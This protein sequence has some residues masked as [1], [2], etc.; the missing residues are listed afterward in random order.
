MA[1]L[2]DYIAVATIVA[3]AV[4]AAAIDVRTRRVPNALNA[5][6]ASI[7]LVLAVT[8]LSAVSVGAAALGLGV[9]LALMLP[10]FIFGA[11]GAGDVKL[12]AAMGTLVGPM[13]IVRA[14]VFTAI[15]GGLLAVA[16]A[17]TRGRLRQ[18][19]ART[20]ALVA[21][22]GSNAAAIEAP[23]ENNRF[24]YAPAIAV[25]CVIAAFGL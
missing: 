9:G 25:G 14:F 22:G 4:A 10:G 19:L 18:T 3:G 21:S 5:L 12:F 20:G 24:P 23:S 1:R 13:H 8:G 15:A 2:S 17:A 6:L 11:M 7:G 16:I